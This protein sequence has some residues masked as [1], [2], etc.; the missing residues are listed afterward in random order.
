MQTDMYNTFD[1]VCLCY[2]YPI[3]FEKRNRDYLRYNKNFKGFWNYGD[4]IEL[5]FN[6][7]KVD[8]DEEDYF[9]DKKL[10]ITF[11]NFRMEQV[12][13]LIPDQFD[14]VEDDYRKLIINLNSEISKTIFKRG[15]YFFSVQVVSNDY[16]YTIS[17]ATD[18]IID[19]I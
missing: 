3:S 15:T 1:T 16:V 9:L 4:T 18:N 14:V 11:F 5:S 10:K 7:K 2:N 17:P 12:Y 19:V 13:E 8:C 6:L